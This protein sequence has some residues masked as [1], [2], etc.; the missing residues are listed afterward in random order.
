ME[1]DGQFYIILGY[2]LPFYTLKTTKNQNKKKKKKK[3][4]KIKKNL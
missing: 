4:L 1:S 3:K 2:F